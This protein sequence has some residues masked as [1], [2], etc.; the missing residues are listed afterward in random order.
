VINPLGN[1]MAYTYVEGTH[2]LKDII[3]PQDR[4]GK[5]KTMTFSYYENGQAYSYVD[6]NGNMESLIYDLFRR[7]TRVTNPRGL[8]TEHYYDENGALI[9]LVE[10]DKG[11]LLFENNDDGL[12]YTKYNALGKR[13]RYSYHSTRSLDGA[14]SDTD[15]QVTREED[16]LGYTTDYDYGIHGQVT[17]VKDKNGNRLTNVYYTTTDP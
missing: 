1:G 3:H 2:W 17:T 6:Q 10:P 16:G 15:G 8:I 13:T 5:Q 9:K 14:A 12:R 11:I 7:R 4:N